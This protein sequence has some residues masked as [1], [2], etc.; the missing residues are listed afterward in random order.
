MRVLVTGARGFIG[1]HCVAEL[2]A[3]GHEVHG[4]TSSGAPGAA[5]GATTHRADLMTGGGAKDV[6]AS[7][8]PTHL[9]HLAWV[10]TP[11][12]FWTDPVNEAWL[13][14][15]RQLIREFTAAG[16]KRV[17]VA[18]TG[19]EYDWTGG[20]CDETSTPLAP[21]TLYG[22]T[23]RALFDDLRSFAPANGLSWAWGR[24]FWLYGPGEPLPRL[25]P[26]IIASLLRDEP[27][28]CTAGTQVRDF[29]HVADV[30]AGLARLAESGVEGAVN[31]ASGAGVAIADVARKIGDRM[32]R[33]HLIALGARPTPA[34]E[35][36][37]VVAAT[38]R[39][40][41]EVGYTPRIG[42]DAG[43]AQ[44][45]DAMRRDARPSGEA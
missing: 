10:T 37:L 14:R 45:I 24:V 21:S 2:V 25:V 22:R 16:G 27:A 35:P 13:E 17:V 29:M 15:S 26:S 23:K 9:L 39:L 40:R 4:I 19:A 7:V 43:L 3:R 28:R 36:P 44:T 33:P 41:D 1:R 42:L 20:V 34:G 12:A 5:D 31:V 30:G 8:R 38:R 11:G 18:G 6:L 32:G